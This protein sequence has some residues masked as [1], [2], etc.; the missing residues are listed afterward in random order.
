MSPAADPGSSASVLVGLYQAG[1]RP[2]LVL[3]D[4]LMG[5]PQ[6]ETAGAALLERTA[7]RGALL[8]TIS[9]LPSH[10]WRAWQ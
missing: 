5:E 9:E 1:G 10:L 3:A 8:A 7:D 6:R 4:D 2:V